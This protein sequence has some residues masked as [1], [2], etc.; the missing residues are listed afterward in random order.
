MNELATVVIVIVIVL[1]FFLH[2]ESKYS[3]LTYVESNIDNRQYLVR[4]VSD[5]QE[6]ADML[7]TIR[8]N[9]D[10][11]VSYLK[12]NNKHDARV[13]RLIDNRT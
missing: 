2:Y 8:K 12:D 6:A 5:K 1:S 13:Q 9:L 4:N 11:I 3:E 7:A 10:S